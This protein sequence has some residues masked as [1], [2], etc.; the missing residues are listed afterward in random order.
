[1]VYSMIS[2]YG[3]IE[4]YARIDQ[5]NMMRGINVDFCHR[6]ITIPIKDFFNRPGFHFYSESGIYY[7]HVEIDSVDGHNCMIHPP[8][9]Q[10]QQE[11]GRNL[12]KT[13][14]VS[15]RLYRQSYSPYIWRNAV[16]EN[17]E[18]FLLTVSDCRVETRL[19]PES[20]GG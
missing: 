8:T 15:D 6:M 10:C 5:N 4:F 19:H 7:L 16:I 2:S 17:G 13:F 12:T 18:K 20:N 9:T 3:D 11:I 14:T 1:M